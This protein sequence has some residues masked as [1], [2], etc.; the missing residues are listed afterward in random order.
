MSRAN[1]CKVHKIQPRGLGREDA[2][3][4]LGISASLFTMMV[5]DGRMPPPKL[6]NARLVWDRRRLDESFE[7]LPER[8]DSNPWDAALGRPTMDAHR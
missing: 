8:P 6:I 7:L 5:E 3:A 1:K 4:Y 2:A